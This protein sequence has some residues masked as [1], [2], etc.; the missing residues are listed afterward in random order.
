ML[1]LWFGWKWVGFLKFLEQITVFYKRF[2][3][4]FH[5]SATSIWKL[6]IQHSQFKKILSWRFEVYQKLSQWMWH[7]SSDEKVKFGLS[8]DWLFITFKTTQLLYARTA[9]S[10]FRC[11][12]GKC[13]KLNH[14]LAKFIQNVLYATLT[15][16][17]SRRAL[18]LV[19]HIW[20]Q[21]VR[22]D[23]IAHS[24]WTI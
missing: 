12:R 17:F 20:Y 10:I 11:F 23:K 24:S 8:T 9:Y 4:K 3:I 22:N 21:M 13:K 2:I 14:Y 15:E 6:A 18:D 7:A 5:S 19:P 1:D 16:W